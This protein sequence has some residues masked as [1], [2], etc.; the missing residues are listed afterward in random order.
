MPDE[1]KF[2]DKATVAG[3]WQHKDGYLMAEAFAVRTGI[4]LYA[5]S[6]VGKPSMRV[7]R[8]YR[9]EDEVKKL[10]SLRT[11]SHAP[12]T[13][14]HP[15]VDVTADNWRDL[16]RGEVST[17]AEWKDG[18]IKLPLIV[19]DAQAI[20]AIE[21][22]SARELSAGYACQ[23]EFVDG[24]S[25]EGEQYDAVQRNIRINHLALVPAGRAGSECRV[26][27]SAWGANP[28]NANDQQ[29]GAQMPGEI[30]PVVLGD[31]AV[32]VPVEI[33]ADVQAFVDSTKATIAAKDA[34]HTAAIAA[35]DAQIATLTG[36][37][38][39]AKAAQM[40]DAQ[41]D[42]KVQ[43]RANLIDLAKRIVSDVDVSKSND[44]IRQAVVVSKIG[45]NAKNQ[46][47]EYYKAA[48]DIFAKDAKPADSFADALRNKTGTPP[49]PNSGNVVDMKALGDAAAAAHTKRNQALEN[50]WNTEANAK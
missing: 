31:R 42:A 25:P 10:D 22:G 40:T 2:T 39:T 30:K 43:E 8:V 33:H 48:F 34:A 29:K 26:G 46:A 20:K 13:L 35:K 23:L 32:N 49:L 17:E 7:V 1:M 15:S 27:D 9:P 16:A 38:D 12:V 36:E 24:V 11:F 41:L 3:T 4:Q 50:A 47:P 21:D 14:G 44:E 45:D 37:R 28:I 6:E 18:K 19:K 5:G